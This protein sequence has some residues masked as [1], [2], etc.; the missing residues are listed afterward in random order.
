VDHLDNVVICVLSLFPLP[1]THS[2]DDD[3]ARAAR[4][5]A[6]PVVVASS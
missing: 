1:L 3:F 4:A 6:M 5:A 2:G